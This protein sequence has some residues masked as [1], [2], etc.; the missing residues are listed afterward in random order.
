M[1]V[2]LI[3]AAFFAG[4]TLNNGVPASNE[5]VS[6]APT[7]RIILPQPNATYLSGVAVNIQA[8]VANAGADI[9]RVEIVIDGETVATLTEPNPNNAGTF[10][11]THGW[12]ASGEGTHSIN[13]TA[14]RGDGSSS[15]PASVEITVIGQGQASATPAPSA[16]LETQQ[17]QSAGGEFGTPEQALTQSDAGATNA[18]ETAPTNV[19]ATP[20]SPT[21]T[22]AQGINVRRG[23]GLVFDPPLGAFAAGQTTEITAIS[24]D[25]LWYKVRFGGSEG[26]VFAALTEASG[27]IASLPRDPGPPAPTAAPPTAIPPTSAPVAT[28]APA[29]SANLVAGIVVL[30]PSQ[31]TCAQTFTIG[32]D[33]ANLGSQPTS[34][35]GTISVQDV[36]AADGTSAGTT[37]GGFPVIQP[38]E[39][40]RINMPLT[41]D[42][43]HSEL[44]RITLVIDSG[45]QIPESV[46]GDNTRTVDYTLQRGNC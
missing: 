18:P 30:D 23:P 42:T 46:E 45:N 36:R 7:V 16:T 4:C 17:Q 32:F 29:S 38:G 10:N 22:F 43:W 37:V 24:T 11:V 3:A 12:S 26:W 14:F 25:G 5:T 33:V 41:V 19:P 8:A 6:G 9:D 28:S 20:S 13:V 15:A 44:H 27:D 35:S 40:V 31:P 1:L 21:A 34:A 2:L 39:T